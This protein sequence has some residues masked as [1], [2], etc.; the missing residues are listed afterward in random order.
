MDTEQME[1][2]D[3]EITASNARKFGESSIARVH[4]SKKYTQQWYTDARANYLDERIP[5][6]CRCCEDGEA[7]TILHILRCSSR[8]E[9]HIKHNRVFERRMKE[10]EAANHLQHLFEAGIELALLDG[11]TH[12]GEEWNGNPNGSRTERTISEL[13]NDDTIPQ[14]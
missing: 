7:E 1:L 13:L 4:F 10:I 9:V 14:Q 11:D 2:I 8:N 6:T 5:A 3:E 12:S